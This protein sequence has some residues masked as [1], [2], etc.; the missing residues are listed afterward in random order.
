MTAWFFFTTK[1]IKI[2]TKIHEGF[3]GCFGF[4]TTKDTKVTLRFTKVLVE[5]LVF[6]HKVSSKISSNIRYREKD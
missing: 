1:S 6:Y 5:C 2:Y 4:F 3:V